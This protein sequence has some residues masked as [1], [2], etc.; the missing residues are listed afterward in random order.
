MFLAN[1]ACLSDQQCG[2]IDRFVHNGGTLI[3]THQTSLLDE[4]GEERGNFGLAELCGLDY[5]GPAADGKD[6]AVAYV[7]QDEA[8]ASEFGPFMC[9]TGRVSKVVPKQGMELE[10]LATRC[11]IE[12]PNPVDHYDP[13]GE[14]DSGEPV[15]TVRQVGAGQAIYINGDVGG[16]FERNPYPALKRFV[17][18]IVERVPPPIAIQA[19]KTVEVTAAVRE[20][21]EL[22]VHLINNPAPHLPNSIGGAAATHFFVEEVTPVHDIEIRFNDF[23]VAEARLPLAGVELE[24]SGK[25][26]AVTV[27][28]VDLH[29]VVVVDL[30]ETV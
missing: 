18:R 29:E 22:L 24:V 6:H 19:P 16:S 28:R 4:L 9:F 1:S 27:P 26:P 17:A 20:S 3:A 23:D 7:L 10:V 13:N 21:G 11:S 15:I 25:V 2:V 12:G 30:K 14:F 5:A 8:L